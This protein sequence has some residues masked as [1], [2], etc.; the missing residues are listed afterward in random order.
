M[1]RITGCILLWK[2]VNY[3]TLD[4][5]DGLTMNPGVYYSSNLEVSAS[6]W[7]EKTGYL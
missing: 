4:S 7:K 6:L 5:D 3:Y 1:S 2:K